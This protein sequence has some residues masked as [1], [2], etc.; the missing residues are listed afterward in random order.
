M[1]KLFWAGLS[2]LCIGLSSCVELDEST[3]ITDDGG[4]VHRTTHNLRD[5]RGREYFPL[6]T[7]ATGKKH[8][9]GRLT[10]PKAIAL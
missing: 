8:T 10:M 1:S 9:L 7:N 6:Q 4:H 2:L 3:L 5:K